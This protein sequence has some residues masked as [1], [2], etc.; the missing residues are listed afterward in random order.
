MDENRIESSCGKNDALWTPQYSLLIVINVITN[1]GFGILLTSISLYT[2]SLGASLA[3][4][5]S[6]ASVFSLVALLMRPI[7]GRL[8]DRYNKRN[9]FILSTVAFG[10][11]AIAYSFTDSVPLLFGIR[12]AH[13]LAFSLS[14]V[15]NMALISLY[16]SKKRMN[17]GLGFYSAGI[18]IGQ[19]IAPTITEWLMD[20]VG[21]FWLYIIVAL[22]IM[23]PPLLCF[24][25]KMPREAR[26]PS[27]PARVRTRF[28]LDQFV[29]RRLL[30]Y[31]VVC[32]MFSL[33]NG[34]ANSFM[35]LIGEAR[36][37]ENIGLFFTVSSIVLLAVRVGMGRLTD[38]MNM[39][40]LVNA[41]LIVSMGSMLLCSRASFLP[42]ILAAAALKAI[43]QGVGQVVLQGEAVKQ[44]EPERVGIAVGTIFMGSDLGNTLG[45][46]IGGAISDHYGYAAMF[47][48][49]IAMFALALV[50]FACYQRKHSRQSA[51]QA[52]P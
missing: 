2:V 18:L 46:V 36:Q 30:L 4:A 10:A 52:D 8:F 25:L 38:R 11:I 45:P 32:G 44:A 19:A 29:V 17:E 20:S 7:G 50:A 16:I 15:T 43:G 37:I 47:Y 51:N 48:W 27:A 21:F 33:Y 1:I 5:G 39:N 34:I 35:F 13:G 22:C 49:G 28:S 3:V 42:V 31:A 26:E 12:V 9:S 14:G 23:L 6:M 24:S 41:A 40:W